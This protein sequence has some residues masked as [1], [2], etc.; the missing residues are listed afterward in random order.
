MQGVYHNG[1]IDIEMQYQFLV[2]QLSRLCG[3]ALKSSLHIPVNSS[4]S[5]L[6]TGGCSYLLKQGICMSIYCVSP[7]CPLTLSLTKCM[8]R[9]MRGPQAALVPYYF[10]KD[11]NVHLVYPCMSLYVC[12]CVKIQ[13]RGTSSE[14]KG[15]ERG[16]EKLQK[17]STKAD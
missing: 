17:Q 16:F 7:G 15:G 12:I 14:V 11:I 6:F 9:T 5:V 3:G 13:G 4:E 2:C 1:F 8:K 10:I